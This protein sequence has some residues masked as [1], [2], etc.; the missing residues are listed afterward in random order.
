MT[1][2]RRL[3]LGCGYS[4]SEPQATLRLDTK[5]GTGT[6]SGTGCVKLGVKPQAGVHG[7]PWPHATDRLRRKLA[8]PT[9]M[10]RRCGRHSAAGSGPALP[11][12]PHDIFGW[13][14][15][16]ATGSAR[17]GSARL[18]RRSDLKIAALQPIQFQL[19]GDPSWRWNGLLQQ[20]IDVYSRRSASPHDL[21]LRSAVYWAADP[22]AGDRTF[23]D[24]SANSRSHAC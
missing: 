3:P 7:H 23:P 19:Q 20:S 18:R 12:P 24:W 21:Q 13:T 15:P 2:R 10:M 11:S 6:R 14:V 22:A 9:P 4:K 17:E 1:K 16:N 5:P 8:S